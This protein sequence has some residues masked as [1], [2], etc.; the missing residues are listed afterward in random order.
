MIVVNDG[1]TDNTAEVASRYPVRIISHAHNRGLAATR[2]TGVRAA[3]H[4][5][6]ASIDADCVPR[7]NWLETLMASVQ[8]LEVA[9]AGG[10]LVEVNRMSLPDRWRC[11]HIPQDLGDHLI[12]DAPFLSGHNTVYKKAAL[13]NVG[14]YNEKL[15]TNFEDLQISE[16]L[17]S[18]GFSL[19]YD[20]RAVVE[21]IRTDTIH[22]ISRTWWRHHFYGVHN[23]ISIRS[24]FGEVLKLVLREW[25][26][27]IRLDVRSHQRDCALIST[28]AI[29]YSVIADLKHLIKCHG[30]PKLYPEHTEC[31]EP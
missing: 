2:N 24:T 14:L 9:G 11:L 7:K 13:E 20:P 10:K 22:S 21:H 25:P 23:D 27:L 6:V 17:R 8:D 31:R 1:S 18:K 4:E 26:F 19:I 5:Y 12:R 15:L 29:V 30:Q 28:V 3:T 16:K